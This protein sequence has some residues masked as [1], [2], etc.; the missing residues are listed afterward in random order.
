MKL[1]NN[2]DKSSLKVHGGSRK[3]AGRKKGAA[4]KKT[5]EIADKAFKSGITP[6]EVMLKAT[7]LLAEYGDEALAKGNKELAIKAYVEA[8]DVAKNAAPY[9]HPRL[10]S[11]EH[12]G[13]D[14]KDLIQRSGVLVVPP[15]LT[16]EEWEKA[17]AQANQ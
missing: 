15:T 10:A 8:A 5:R 17:V 16:L 1:E 9:M 6:L 12:T 7:Y 11:V 4:T 14:G 2:Q 3:N 13:K